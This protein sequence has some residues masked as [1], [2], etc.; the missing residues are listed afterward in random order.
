MSPASPQAPA[1]PTPCAEPAWPAVAADLARNLHDFQ[2]SLPSHLRERA[3]ALIE[4]LRLPRPGRPTPAWNDLTLPLAVLPAWTAAYLRRQGHSVPRR[5]VRAAA[6]SAVLG[7]LAVR[8][9]D[10]RID[11]QLGDEAEALLLGSALLTAHAAQ[12]AVAA[13]PRR[14][15]AM[16]ARVAAAWAAYAEAMTLEA[17][18]GRDREPWTAAA[19]SA[20]LDRYAPMTLASDALLLR[21]GRPQAI[22]PL[23]AAI[24]GLVESHQLFE[25]TTD[26]EQDAAAGQTTYVAVLLGQPDAKGRVVPARGGVAGVGRTVALADQCAGAAAQAARAAGHDEL[27]AHLERR[28]GAMSGWVGDIEAAL[29]ATVMDRSW[30]GAGG[31]G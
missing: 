14:A 7:Y 17:R 27:A 9:H 26:L 4:Q 18:L 11:E 31:G 20:T 1:L 2:G 19:W 6:L 23:Q 28:R 5:A 30:N 15:V 24:T 8:L 21:A 22:A 3:S 13:G 16:A 12:L 29:L 10:D 25:D